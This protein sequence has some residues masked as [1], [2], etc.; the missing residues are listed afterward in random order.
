[1]EYLIINGED[2]ITLPINPSVVTVEDSWKNEEVDINK[3]GLITLIGK[4]ALRSV[5][6]ESFFPAQE[7]GFAIH[8]EHCDDP[9]FYIR[10]LSE[11]RGQMLTFTMTETDNY[12]SWPCVI[13]DLQYGFREADDDIFYT[14]RLKE[15]KQ[16]A[17]TRKMPDTKKVTYT[18]KK[19]DNLKSI[20]KKKLG[21]SS[22]AKKAYNQNKSAIDKGVKREV[23]RIKKKDPAKAKTYK[24]Q[25]VLTKK[26]P[27]GIKLTMK[28]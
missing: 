22:Y 16:A 12:I 25:S 13:D 28:V 14:L 24:L 10:K 4:R 2:S 27:K 11:W 5:T 15:Y 21:K 17:S 20:A 23:K 7:Y 8:T 6:I 18:T 3:I 26:L 1:M 19:G 9:F